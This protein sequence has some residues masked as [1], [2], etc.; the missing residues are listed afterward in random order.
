MKLILAPRASAILYNLL[1][2]RADFRPWLLPANICPIVPMTFFKARVPFEFVDISASTLH[3]D[4]EQAEEKIRKGKFGGLLY[5]HTYGDPAA[6]L[7]FF[8]AV[9][10]LQPDLLLLDDRCLCVPDLEPIE[11]PADALLYSTGYAKIAE[12]GFGGYAFA[13]EDLAYR[14]ARLPFNPVHHEKMERDYK[15]ALRKRE[16]FVYRDSDWLQIDPP[17][18]AWYDYSRQIEETKKASLIQRLALNQIYESLLPREIQL[19]PAYQIWRFNI[20]VGNQAEILNAIFA[21]GL[22]ASSHYASLAGI[23]A[24]GSAPRAEALAGGVVNLFND[25]RFDEQKARQTCDAILRNL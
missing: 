25:K 20:R 7:E 1:A 9:K 14:A 24:D 21:A 15:E 3:M 13:R 4:L 8:S 17:P 2:G 10:A 22:F 5:A 16:R 18:P 23:M 19:S 6:P 12:L 11:T